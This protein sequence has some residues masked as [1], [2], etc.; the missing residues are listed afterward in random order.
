MK[1]V[2]HRYRAGAVLVRQPHAGV[3]RLPGHRLAELLLGVPDL[4]RVEPAGKFLDR[5]LGHAPSRLRPEEFVEVHRLDGIVRA[6]AVPGGRC[7]QPGGV[8]GLGGIK[9]SVLVG[10]A[11]E[12]L[13]HGNGD[14]EKRFGHGLSVIL[15]WGAR[16]LR[17]PSS[18]EQS[19]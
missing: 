8:I 12:R 14:D 10:R 16:V 18:P 11:H 6:D 9:P 5:G 19:D 7:S 4:G 13:V 17:P 2:V 15:F 3:D 1:R